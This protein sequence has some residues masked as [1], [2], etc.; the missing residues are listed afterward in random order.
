[1]RKIIIL[2]FFIFITLPVFA[3]KK[4]DI[5]SMS[6][7]QA[8]KILYEFELKDMGIDR[9]KSKELYNY[10]ESDAYAIFYDLNSD[11]VDE[12]IG[13]IYSTYFYCVQGYELF[14]LKRVN[15]EYERITYVHFFPEGDLHILDSK[16]AGYSDLKVHHTRIKSTSEPEFHI[17]LSDAFSPVI[18]NDKEQC[19]MYFSPD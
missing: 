5:Y 12:I 15:N 9:K 2:I 10:D 14:I 4:I 13:F 16:T 1:M 6:N 17:K 7:P 8:A 11:G 3:D 19:Y 18:Y